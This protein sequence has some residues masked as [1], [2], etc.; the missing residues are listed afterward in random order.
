[1]T[2]ALAA[3]VGLIAGLGVAWI[4]YYFCFARRRSDGNGI[5]EGLLE[6]I[7]QRAKVVR[8]GSEDVEMRVARLQE[9]RR[10]R[11]RSNSHNGNGGE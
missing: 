8:Q 10:I 9:L 11:E 7:A 5:T 2:T 1:M 6:D 3:M 4:V